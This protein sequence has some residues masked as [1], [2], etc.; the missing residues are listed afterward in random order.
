MIETTQLLSTIKN[1]LKS[2][3]ITYRD[4]AHTLNLLELSVKRVLTSGRPMPLS[5]RSGVG[6]LLAVHKWEPEEFRK[7]RR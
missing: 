6:L 3:G 2:Q 5:K 4:V 1:K 7:L